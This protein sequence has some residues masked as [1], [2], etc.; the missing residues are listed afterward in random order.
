MAPS[1]AVSHDTLRACSNKHSAG[2][3]PPTRPPPKSG[4]PD[5]PEGMVRIFVV[6]PRRGQYEL[7]VSQMETAVD[8]KYHLAELKKVSDSPASARMPRSA[9][10]ADIRLLFKGTP[11]K[12]G[13][14]LCELG[15]QN[16]S[17]LRALPVLRESRMGLHNTAPRG[18]LMTSTRPWRPSQSREPLEPQTL[19][20]EENS[21]A[22]TLTTYS[23]NLVCP[24]LRPHPALPTPK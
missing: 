17:L 23:G 21:Y 12:P 2:L 1:C 14:P 10:Q 13:V 4:R 24:I 3:L 6:T 20:V 22:A 9:E 8:L 16:G 7:E 15:L 18:L 19:D 5:P 11:L